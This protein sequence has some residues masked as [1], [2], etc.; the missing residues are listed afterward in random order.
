MQVPQKEREQARLAAAIR[1]DQPDL[2][3]GMHGRIRAVEQAFRAAGEREVR[4]PDQGGATY[5]VSA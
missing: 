4:N 5:S 2:V 3:P 1:P